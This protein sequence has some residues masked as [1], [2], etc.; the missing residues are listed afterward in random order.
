VKIS[1]FAKTMN[2][3]ASRTLTILGFT[4]LLDRMFSNNCFTGGGGSPVGFMDATA[5]SSAQE[6]CSAIDDRFGAY[7]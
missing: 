6:V 4:D 3:G 5:S 7:S 1:G 2:A